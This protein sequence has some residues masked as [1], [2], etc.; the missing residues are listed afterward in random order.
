MCS[1]QKVCVC[2]PAPHCTGSVCTARLLLRRPHGPARHGAALRARGRQP[3]AAFVPLSREGLSPPSLVST[4]GGAPP[5]PAGPCRP[6]A[7]TMPGM[8]VVP[9]ALPGC[10]DRR[11]SLRE[12][13]RRRPARTKGG[14]GEAAPRGWGRLGEP[15]GCGA[16]GNCTGPAAAG[17]K[18]RWGPLAVGGFVWRNRSFGEGMRWA[19]AERGGLRSASP[20]AFVPGEGSG[21]LLP[22]RGDGAPG[23]AGTRSYPEIGG[24]RRLGG[25][26][27][28][29]SLGSPQQAHRSFPEPAPNDGF[30]WQMGWGEAAV[31]YLIWSGRERA[32]Q[33]GAAL[34]PRPRRRQPLT[35]SAARAP[36][37]ARRPHPSPQNAW[38]PGLTLLHK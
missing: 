37:A 33:P 34:P 8:S 13:P 38:Q 21:P 24:E 5:L 23:G 27:P 4:G 18:I 10:G 36:P 9:A 28:G 22:L 25:A 6:G 32:T 16:V 14:R 11:G 3:E 19:V 29:A 31:L 20:L 7:G 35:L 12:R 17:A 15:G 1:K 26:V 30:R 2:V